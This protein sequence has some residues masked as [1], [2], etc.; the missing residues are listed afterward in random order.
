MPHIFGGYFVKLVSLFYGE[1]LEYELYDDGGGAD[2]VAKG[3][4]LYGGGSDEP[5][6]R[7]GRLDAVLKAQAF[8]ADDLKEQMERYAVRDEITERLFEYL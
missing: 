6:S 5:G 2:P 1:S 8:A 7:A 4:A 3:T